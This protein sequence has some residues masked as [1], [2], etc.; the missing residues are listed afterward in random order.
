MTCLR[1]GCRCSRCEAPATTTAPTVD[2]RRQ[3]VYRQLVE[4]V[5]RA[6]DCRDAVV[7]EQCRQRLRRGLE[8][9]AALV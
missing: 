5:D 2:E 3:A 7:C 1:S 9:L 4:D 8:D 6:L